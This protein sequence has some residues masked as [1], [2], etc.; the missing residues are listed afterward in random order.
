ML[1]VLR[2]TRDHRLLM[3]LALALQP[4]PE[5]DKKYLFDSER[6]Q[7]AAVALSLM[8]QV[9]RSRLQEIKDSPN[10]VPGSDLTQVSPQQVTQIVYFHRSF[11]KMTKFCQFYSGLSKRFQKAV[12]ADGRIPCLRSDTAE[13][14]GQRDGLFLVARRLLQGAPRV[15]RSAGDGRQRHG[16]GLDFLP[17]QA[18][19]IE[20]PRRRRAWRHGWIVVGRRGHQRK[21]RLR[22]TKRKSD[23]VRRPATDH[24]GPS[25]RHA[26]RISPGSNQCAYCCCFRPKLDQRYGGSH[27]IAAIRRGFRRESSAAFEKY[28]RHFQPARHVL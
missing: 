24:L 15:Q 8:Q 26:P 19:S 14:A 27:E 10:V 6:E 9:L 11:R 7:H 12:A 17:Q 25:S 13:S 3:E 4:E 18:S 2:D 23:R 28:P 5:P 16:A 20:S 22:T 1:D 21:A